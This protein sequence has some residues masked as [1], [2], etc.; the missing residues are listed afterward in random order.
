MKPVVRKRL[1]SSAIRPSAQRGAIAEYVLSTK[2]HPS[3]DEVWR[4]VRAR[5]PEVSRAT[6]Y[7]TLG[8]FVRQGLLRELVLA[9]GR[10]V[11]DPHVAPHHH[12]VDDRTGEIHDVP[13]E[14]IRVSG[15][16]GL[17]GIEAREVHV[18]IHGRRRAKKG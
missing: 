9:P 1:E 2:D 5:F 16:K 15:V 4:A 11:Y 7:N 10:I 14:A 6:V 17:R 8:L 12:F 3:A 13:L 18:V